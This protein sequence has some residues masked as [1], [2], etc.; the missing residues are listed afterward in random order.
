MV[1]IGA[2]MKRNDALKVVIDQWLGEGTHRTRRVLS[3]KSGVNYSSIRNAADG[4]EV[5]DDT[6][7]RIVMAI[8]KPVEIHAFAA[9]F[10]PK[11]TEFTKPFVDFGAQQV[12]ASKPLTRKHCECIAALAFGAS[13]LEA[14]QMKL[15]SSAEAVLEDLVAAEIVKHEDGRFMLP[16]HE[17]S[18]SSSTVLVELARIVLDNFQWEERGNQTYTRMGAVSPET[19]SKVYEILFEAEKKIANLVRNPENAGPKKIGYTLTMTSF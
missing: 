10:I 11:L 13:T 3:E 8:K 15:G 2:V 1:G 7:L 19:Q 18:I 14:L 4:K 16:A 17:L 12:Q 9:E 6:A 5:N